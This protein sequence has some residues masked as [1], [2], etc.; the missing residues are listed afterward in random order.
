[1]TKPFDQIILTND[2]LGHIIALFMARQGQSTYLI[3]DSRVMNVPFVFRNLNLIDREFLRHMGTELGIKPLIE[4]DYYLHHRNRQILSSGEVFKLSNSAFENTLEILRKWSF[5]Q[6]IYDELLSLEKRRFDPLFESYAEIIADHCY[7]YENFQTLSSA[8]FFIGEETS[9]KNVLLKLQ[10]NI[11]RYLK[12]RPELLNHLAQ[13]FLG[14]IKRQYTEF[15]LFY[16]V[17]TLLSPSYHLNEKK[18]NEHLKFSLL[19]RE[20]EHTENLL[21]AIEL[22]PKGHK[23][24][25]LYNNKEPLEFKKILFHGERYFGGPI[26]IYRKNNLYRAYVYKGKVSG[27]RFS[28]VL[29]CSIIVSDHFDYLWGYIDPEGNIEMV[30]F[31]EEYVGGCKQELF[32]IATGRCYSLFKKYGLLIDEANFELSEQAEFYGYLGQSAERNTVQQVQDRLSG[33]TVLRKDFKTAS[34]FKRSPSGLFKY[35]NEIK[36]YYFRA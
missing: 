11:S 20:G 8:I 34:Y 5:D 27:P 30:F 1:M 18:L 35:L 9:F 4:I 32:K 24:V 36:S 17:Y 25:H 3:A 22:Q 16:I 31:A 19:E 10:K 33:Q 13:T 21:A 26:G 29:D 14:N 6:E 23:K 12:S 15:E 2:Y 7:R 28:S